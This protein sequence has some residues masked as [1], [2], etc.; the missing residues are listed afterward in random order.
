VTDG[1]STPGIGLSH[2]AWSVDG[3]GPV[4]GDVV[5]W[6]GGQTGTVATV[7][8]CAETSGETVTRWTWAV[9]EDGRLLEI[10][11]RGCAVY[12]PPV[13]F[14]NGTVPYFALVAQDGALVRFEERVRAGVWET[15]PVRLSLERRRWRVTSTGTVT[16]RRLGPVTAGGWGQ[17]GIRAAA[18]QDTTGASVEAPTV[19]LFPPGIGE[20]L[21]APPLPHVAPD[22]YFTLAEAGGA[23]GLGI[24]LWAI[25]VCVAF[26]RRLGDTPFGA[27]LRVVGDAA[28]S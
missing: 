5:A 4:P 23:T 20:S 19:P 27:G 18:A 2:D 28:V 12:D 17:I 1:L 21:A 11:P 3:F 25:D 9:F 10:A 8:L 14:R 16:A 6:P 22:V 26:G 15:R 7:Y 13:L 24:G